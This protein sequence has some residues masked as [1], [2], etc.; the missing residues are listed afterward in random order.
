VPSIVPSQKKEA[1]MLVVTGFKNSQ[2]KQYQQ[3]IYNKDLMSPDL[4]IEDLNGHL[5]SKVSNASSPSKVGRIGHHLT[6][7]EA[8]SHRSGRSNTKSK[9]LSNAGRAVL[10]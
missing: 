2:E 6:N 7:L 3:K 1:P 9:K 5:S 4:K 8:L 10:K